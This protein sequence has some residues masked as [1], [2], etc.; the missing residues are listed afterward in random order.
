[1]PS[2]NERNIVGQQLLTLLD[3]TC[4]VRLHTLLHVMILRVVG[5]CCATFETGQ[6]F[7]PGKR[8]QH[9]WVTTPNIFG[10]CCVHLHVDQQY[11]DQ[12]ESII[13]K[14]CFVTVDNANNHHASMIK[15]A[16]QPLNILEWQAKTHIC[17]LFCEFWVVFYLS[18]FVTLFILG[19]ELTNHLSVFFWKRLYLFASTHSF[20][21][22]FCRPPVKRR[23]SASR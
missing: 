14:I 5:S 18:L 15:Q 22:R 1:M 16:V 19:L 21:R 6:T 13:C 3:V 12:D 10:S 2:A 20:S 7:R 8:T 4:C 23:K 11:W 9:F 17:T